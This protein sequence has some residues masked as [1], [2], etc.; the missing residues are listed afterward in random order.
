MSFNIAIDG[1]AGAGKST[2]ARLLAKKLGFIYVD[3]GAMYRAMALHF[4]NRGIE[5]GQEDAIREACREVKISLSYENGQQKVFL[6][7]EDVSTAIRQEQVGKMASLTSPYPFVREKLLSLQRGMAQEHDVIMDGRDIGTCILPYA[8]LKIF[9][10]ASV[11]TRAQRRYQ[12]LVDK[13]ED[14]DLEQIK[15]DI[16]ARDHADMTRETAPLKQAEDAIL[17]D[18]SDLDIDGV[19]AV[20]TDLA[21]KAGVTIA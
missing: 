9:L 5:A 12:E 20:M 2:I 18:T 19:V 21:V 17:V 1:P 7:G 16:A 11:E 14:C 3:T 13:G 10:T 6:N 8:Q 4:L 15:A